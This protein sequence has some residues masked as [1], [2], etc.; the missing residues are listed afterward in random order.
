MKKEIKQILNT[1]GVTS[2]YKGYYPTIDAVEMFVNR[3]GERIN[4]SQEL[5]PQLSHKYNMSCYSIERNIHTIANKAYRSNKKLL[6]TLLDEEL[7]K[8]PSNYLF[9]EAI[10]FYIWNKNRVGDINIPKSDSSRNNFSSIVEVRC[11]DYLYINSLLSH[12]IE[13]RSNN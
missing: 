6:G 2:K 11:Y 12:G 13:D 9:L 1:L 7:A 10:A 3:Y 5:Y 8:C 4:L